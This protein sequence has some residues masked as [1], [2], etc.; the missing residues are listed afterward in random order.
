MEPNVNFDQLAKVFW[1]FKP[2]LSSNPTPNGSQITQAYLAQYPSGPIGVMQG[3]PGTAQALH[4]RASITPPS[5]T[6]KIPKIG[7]H[8]VVWDAEMEFERIKFIMNNPK[9]R[10]LEEGVSVLRQYGW[11]GKDEDIEPLMNQINLDL[12]KMRKANILRSSIHV[13]LTSGDVLILSSIKRLRKLNRTAESPSMTSMAQAFY[14]Y[15]EDD[16]ILGL[17]SLLI[18]LGTDW[19]GVQKGPF[20]YPSPLEY[21]IYKLKLD[22]V[23]LFIQHGMRVSM[24]SII[25]LP[26]LKIPT[27]EEEDKILEICEIFDGIAKQEGENIYKKYGMSLLECT[28]TSRRVINKF[29]EKGF[30]LDPSQALSFAVRF[31]QPNLEVI[32]WLLK[33]LKADPHYV[34]PLYDISSCINVVRSR[35][36]D[37]PELLNVVTN[38]LQK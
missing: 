12:R 20:Y 36:S 19:T 8:E 38:A 17:T 1:E 14:K 35:A 34:N 24:D 4:K 32:S 13:S 26:S 22:F 16:N 10:P 31:P 30:T 7:P 28:L 33:D 21:A 15:L 5:T 29:I 2:T 23:K 18:L 11:K 6:P 25:Y 3:T 9:Q 37:H 27:P